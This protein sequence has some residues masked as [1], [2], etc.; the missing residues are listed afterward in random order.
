VDTAV[1]VIRENAL[2]PPGDLERKKLCFKGERVREP[3][4]HLLSAI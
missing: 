3:V 2:F 4:P 1:N